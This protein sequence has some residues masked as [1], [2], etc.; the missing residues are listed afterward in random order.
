[1]NN[2]SNIPPPPPDPKP[3]LG[4]TPGYGVCFNVNIKQSKSQ[5]GMIAITDKEIE[6]IKRFLFGLPSDNEV[7]KSFGNKIFEESLRRS[8]GCRCCG[9]SLVDGHCCYCDG[10]DYSDM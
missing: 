1:M 2:K 6:E 9:S 5:S 10:K 7:I 3:Q 4:N 8:R